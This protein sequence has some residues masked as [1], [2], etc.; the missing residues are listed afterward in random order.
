M[1]FRRLC[2]LEQHTHIHSESRAFKCVHC[3][4]AFKQSSVRDGHQRLCKS[5]FSSQNER[6][7]FKRF[8]CSQ[9][10]QRFH[11]SFNRNRHERTHN[12]AQE[13]LCCQYC[14][15][16]YRRKDHLTRHQKDELP[17]NRLTE[18]SRVRKLQRMF[19]YYHISRSIEPNV[20]FI[21]EWRKI[22]L[23]H[24]LKYKISGKNVIL[25]K[26]R[27]RTKMHYRF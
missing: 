14:D 18:W 20:L 24:Q 11:T 16:R 5:A 9:C 19:D 17:N 3:S 8:S 2:L 15:C 1:L 6:D 10:G 7:A 25:K 13:Y 27:N 22:C 4:L 21:Y 23:T 12:K 26:I